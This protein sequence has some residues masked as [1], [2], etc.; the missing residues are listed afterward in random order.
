MGPIVTA[1]TYA[2]LPKD[3]IILH[4]ESGPRPQAEDAF[5][6]GHLPGARL[7]DRDTLT[8][9]PMG[10]GDG[11]HPLP[12]PD[13]FAAAL[14]E[15]GVGPD[16]T[17]LA[18]DRCAGVDAAR[19]VYL[20]RVLGQR[21]ALLDGGL[22]GYTDTLETGP[23]PAV[24]PVERAPIPWPDDLVEAAV[25]AA[26]IAEA[27]VVLDARSGE[28]YRGEDE[29]LDPVAGHIPGAVNAP[30]AQNLDAEGH[31][32]A[33]PKLHARFSDLGVDQDTIVYCGSGV[34]AAHELLA[35][36]HA[37]LG[38]PRLYVG[39]WSQWCRSDRPIATGE[40]P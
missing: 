1:A 30:F 6:A 25:V 23:S 33:P 2:A 35:I 32:R 4:V 12:T 13:A 39:S 38:L 26:H 20:L 19:L 11:R 10:P 18:Y 31:F 37:G 27:G 24:E 34:T 28:R 16:A 15:A 36:E 22:Q 40:Q 29:P 3:V 21:A 9:A 14:A 7:V 17:V 5:A 8:S